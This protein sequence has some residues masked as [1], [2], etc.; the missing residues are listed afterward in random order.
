MRLTSLPEPFANPSLTLGRLSQIPSPA[1]SA[2]RQ[3]DTG[4]YTA[5]KLSA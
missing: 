4:S 1:D 3:S 5:E 2:A